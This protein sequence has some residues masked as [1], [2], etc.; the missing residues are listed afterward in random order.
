MT[1]ED[2]CEDDD[3]ALWIDPFEAEALVAPLRAL[4]DPNRVR[5]LARIARAGADGVCVCVLTEGSGL[6][7]PSVSH[8][9]AILRQVGVVGRRRV[10]NYAYYALA[11]GALDAVGV[12]LA[13]IDPVEI[14]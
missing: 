4:A 14:A 7:Q 1:P 13:K 12:V 3:P 9:L 2:L 5:L 10:G 8:H 11:P 6:S